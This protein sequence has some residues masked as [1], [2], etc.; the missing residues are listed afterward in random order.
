MLLISTCLVQIREQS[1]RS[2][3]NR[4]G[5]KLYFI[6]STQISEPFA[7]DLGSVNKEGNTSTLLH[8]FNITHPIRKLF[9][10]S[11]IYIAY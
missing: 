5:V 1:L 11:L 2:F 7:Y 10:L 4:A 3:Q 9:V 8:S 6:G